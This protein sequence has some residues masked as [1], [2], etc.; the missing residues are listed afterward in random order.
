MGQCI[1]VRSSHVYLHHVSD[2]ACGAAIDKFRSSLF[3]C[4]RARK[5]FSQI[6]IRH[7]I[8]QVSIES[9]TGSMQFFSFTKLI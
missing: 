3:D 8:W 4:I 2:H 9:S 7:I 6:S 1:L 5:S